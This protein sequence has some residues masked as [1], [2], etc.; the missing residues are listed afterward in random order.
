MLNNKFFCYYSKTHYEINNLLI[1]DKLSLSFI[2][3]K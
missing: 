1:K 2:M 3:Y